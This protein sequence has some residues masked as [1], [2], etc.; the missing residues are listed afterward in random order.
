MWSRPMNGRKNNNETTMLQYKTN[1]RRN[2]LQ[3]LKLKSLINI[4]P[5]TKN[6]VCAYSTLCNNIKVEKKQKLALCPSV[7]SKIR[8]VIAQL[9]SALAATA[10]SWG[11]FLPRAL[12]RVFFVCFNDFLLRLALKRGKK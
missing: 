12:A 4:T 11:W 9:F 7:A 6:R 3:E 10:G 5:H 8:M 1:T 2:Y